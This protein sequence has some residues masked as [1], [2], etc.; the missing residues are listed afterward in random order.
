MKG[1][2]DVGAN[3]CYVEYNLGIGLMKRRG[4]NVATFN[5]PETNSVAFEA[6][7]LVDILQSI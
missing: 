5:N 2:S 7:M 3:E 6:F 4:I 1:Q